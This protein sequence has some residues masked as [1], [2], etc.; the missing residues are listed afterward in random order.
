MK[1]R[2][3]L[4]TVRVYPPIPIREF[5]WCAYHED[6]VEAARLYGWGRTEPEAVADLKQIIAD[7]EGFQ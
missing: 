4:I 3:K 5:D 2:G 6:D 7:E 1:D